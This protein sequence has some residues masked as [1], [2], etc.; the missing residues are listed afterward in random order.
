VY[1]ARPLR[2]VVQRLLEN[3]LAMRIIAGEIPEGATVQVDAEGNELLFH[4]R[5]PAPVAG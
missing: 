5:H 2:R 3:P 4:T 1:G